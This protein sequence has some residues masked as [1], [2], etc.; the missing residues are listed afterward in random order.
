MKLYHGTNYSSAINICSNGIDLSCSK[1]SLDLGPGFYAK[2]SYHRAAELAVKKT[3]KVN[4]QNRK[5][6]KNYKYEEPYVVQFEYKPL[7]EAKLE[8]I[9]FP[10]H[11][12]EW[13]AFVLNNRLTPEILS[14]YDIENHNQ[15][16]RYDVCIGEIADGAIINSAFQVNNKILLPEDINFEAFLKDNKEPYGQ[17]YSFHSK[18]SISCISGLS[19]DIIKNKRRYTK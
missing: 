18:K 17:Q 8:Q 13:G 1:P 6:Q 5:R 19:C 16:C 9:S 7:P 15:D 12:V 14:Q 2:P 10:H 11:G 4:E 3:D